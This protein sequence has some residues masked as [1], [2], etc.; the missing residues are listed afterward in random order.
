MGVV[1]TVETARREEAEQARRPLPYYNSAPSAVRPDLRRPTAAA[2]TL[3]WRADTTRRAVAL[4]FDD[5]PHPQWTPRVTA[6]LADYDVPATFFVKGV[7]VRDH[8]ALHAR[9]LDRHELGNHTWDHP[10][11]GRLNEPACLGQL[12]RCSAEMR[13]AWG[14][15]PTLFRPPYGHVGGAAILAAAELG[16]STVLWSAQLRER[17]YVHRPAGIV[18]DIAASV[19]PGAIVLGHDT[20]RAVRLV[21]IDRLRA[22]I[23]RLLADG[24]TFYTVSDLLALERP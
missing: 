16:M 18:D 22:I 4:T 2:T 7:N 17:D 10:D 24:Y 5:G 21:A 6:A 13:R 9:D 14:R 1:G 11:L 12:R 8:A 3:H 23:E 19:H 20:G 15:E